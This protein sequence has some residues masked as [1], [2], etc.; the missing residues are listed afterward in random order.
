ME[1]CL[2]KFAKKA[3]IAL[4]E[5]EIDYVIIGGFAAIVYGR[6]RTTMGIDIIL[7]LN[8]DD[9]SMIQKLVNVLSKYNLETQERD[10]I[11]ALNEKSHFSIFDNASPMRIDAKGIY[12]NLDRITFLNRKEVEVF[13]IKAWLETPEDLILAKL[14]YG[15]QQDIEDVV[16]VL[17]NMRDQIDLEYLERR[18]MKENVSNMLRKIISSI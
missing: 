6:P 17:I 10:I 4:N 8:P 15:S 16:A 2:E 5:S 3:I 9:K 1:G 12:G 7:N 18:A 13:G 11:M 14:V